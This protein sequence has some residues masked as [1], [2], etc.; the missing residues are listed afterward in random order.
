MATYLLLKERAIRFRQDR[1]SRRRCR[2]PRSS[3]LGEPTLGDGETWKELVAD[4]TEN[5]AS[6]TDNLRP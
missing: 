5:S 4:V 1:E 6:R 3:E 2:S